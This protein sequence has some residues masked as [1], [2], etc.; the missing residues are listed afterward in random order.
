M[1]PGSVRAVHPNP[2]PSKVGCQAKSL[3]GA[4]TH[5][6]ACFAGVLPC[7]GRQQQGQGYWTQTQHPGT[8]QHICQSSAT[9]G[10]AWGLSCW[11]AACC[12]IRFQMTR[13]NSGQDAFAGRSEL[14]NV[15][16]GDSPR[17]WCCPGL[18]PAPLPPCQCAVAP[19]A[20]MTGGT[21]LPQRIFGPFW[22]EV[23]GQA[24]FLQC[25]KCQV[26]GDNL[27]PLLQPHLLPN[28]LQTFKQCSLN[29]TQISCG[30][31][32]TIIKKDLS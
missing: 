10:R 22:C 24:Q 18:L 28:I 19:M 23:P 4:A 1:C 3:V 32:A 30:P 27:S 16:A 2:S 15:T 8:V 5:S 7:A 9:S 31:P 29:H 25:W 14:G 20:G 12:T 17:R 6:I 21:W 13:N 11:V 26:V